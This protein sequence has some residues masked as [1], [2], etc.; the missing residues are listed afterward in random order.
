MT[1]M[2]VDTSAYS[3]FRRG[4]ADVVAHLDRA[5]WVGM[6]TVVL[7]ELEAGFAAGRRRAANRRELRL[8]LAESI[9]HVLPVDHEVAEI[10]GDLVAA[11]R[12]AGTPIP[13]NDVWIAA[14]AI[15]AGAVVLTFDAHF[16]RVPRL[17]SIVCG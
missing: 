4:Q 9:V 3:H 14:T 12:A 11:L 8:L 5:S 13:A 16:R 6:P 17:G 15:R 1:R 10:Y 2:V 7:G